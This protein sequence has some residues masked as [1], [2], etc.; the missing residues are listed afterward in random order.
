MIEN[1]LKFQ[2]S[3]FTIELYNHSYVHT[4]ASGTQVT[5]VESKSYK[6]EGSCIWVPEYMF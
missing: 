5:L 6:C 2:N 1:E 3:F 4:L